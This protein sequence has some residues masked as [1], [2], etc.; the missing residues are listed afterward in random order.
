MRGLL[1]KDFALMKNQMRSSFIIIAIAV[2]MM[3]VNDD[4][5]FSIAY[6]TMVFGI[7][8]ISSISYDDFDKGYTFLFTLPISRREYVLSKYVFAMLSAL[9]GA[10]ISAV[11]LAA[12]LIAKGRISEF[13][14]E[15]GFVAGYV[16]G[17]FCLLAVMIP[18]ELKFGVEKG[19]IAL[20]VIAAVAV[21]GGLALSKLPVNTRMLVILEKFASLSQ[22]ALFGIFIVICVIALVI[23]YTI[24]CRIMEKKE[25]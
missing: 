10:L 13:S 12:G 8:G 24:S 4:L 19:R 3:F 18:I 11:L 7:F 16:L 20:L 21:A 25:F 22:I 1:L 15:I 5:S 17:V 2:F 14:G 9:T 23:S 6:I